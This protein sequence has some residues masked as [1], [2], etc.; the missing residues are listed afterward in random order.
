MKKY[1]KTHYFW[2]S[3]YDQ[4]SYYSMNIQIINKPKIKIIDYVSGFI[5]CQHDLH[6]AYF[7]EL[8]QEY[9]CHLEPSQ[10]Y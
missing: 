7:I 8:V 1:T 2:G 3:W 4:K 10:Y 6:Y 5:G 9:T